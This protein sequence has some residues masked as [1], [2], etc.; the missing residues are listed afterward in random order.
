MRTRRRELEATTG[1]KDLHPKAGRLGPSGHDP[2]QPL[3]AG[4]AW[5][6]SPLWTVLAELRRRRVA[7]RWGVERALVT[8]PASMRIRVG[9]VGSGLTPPSC[10]QGGQSGSACIGTR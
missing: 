9:D 3:V 10:R 6:D 5:G 8:E 4:T 7:W 1:S 2:L